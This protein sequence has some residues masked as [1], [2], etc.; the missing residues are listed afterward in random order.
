MLL[1][2]PPS[3][4][5][6]ISPPLRPPLPPTNPSPGG[7][8]APGLLAGGRG[9]RT[10]LHFSRRLVGAGLHVGPAASHR[11]PQ[12]PRLPHRL[13]HPPRPARRRRGGGRAGCGLWAGRRRRRRRHLAGA[14]LFPGAGWGQRGFRGQPHAGGAAVG[15][16]LQLFR[17]FEG[18]ACTCGY[19]V[20]GGGQQGAARS[21]G[22]RRARRRGAAGDKPRVL[23]VCRSAPTPGR[24][25][26]RRTCRRRFVL[27]PEG[28]VFREFLLDELV[29]RGR[30][31]GVV[32]VGGM[33]GVVEGGNLFM[34]TGSCRN[35]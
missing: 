30:G 19:G 2:H 22:M 15:R 4:V 24:S 11:L 35:G 34:V 14:H 33:V 16:W 7:G 18:G 1:P 17:S 10:H 21:R 23:A 8:A 5:V 9:P 3:V 27:S 31:S 29:R 20:A 25:P 28:A 26:A 6:P 13:P 12:P 32:G